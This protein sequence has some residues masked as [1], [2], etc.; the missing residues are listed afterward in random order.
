MEYLVREPYFIT[1][2][3]LLY[4]ILTVDFEV[5]KLIITKLIHKIS[6]GKNYFKGKKFFCSILFSI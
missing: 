2:K 1:L 4:S 5:N 3:F 6:D